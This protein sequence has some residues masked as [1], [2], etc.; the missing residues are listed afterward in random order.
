MI[1]LQSDTHDKPDGNIMLDGTFKKYEVIAFDA[2]VKA[3][4]VDLG[5]ILQNLAIEFQSR[6]QN[7]R[8]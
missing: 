4:E 8:V 6:Y 5:K 1:L 3:R 7:Q 2:D